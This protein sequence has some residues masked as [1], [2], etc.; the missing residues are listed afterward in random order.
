MDLVAGHRDGS[1]THYNVERGDVWHQVP[2][3]SGPHAGAAVQH[4]AWVEA[5]GSYTGI[6]GLEVRLPFGFALGVTFGCALPGPLTSP[7]VRRLIHCPTPSPLSPA[8]HLRFRHVRF[9][10]RPPMASDPAPKP[11][12]PADLDLTKHTPAVPWPAPPTALHMLVSCDSRG[13]AC[14]SA[15]GQLQVAVV[16]LRVGQPAGGQTTGDVAAQVGPSRP[17]CLRKSLLDSTD[18]INI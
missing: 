10:G 18:A 17:P 12:T 15:Y 14:I 8:Q 5:E 9:F 6:P 11:P 16:D 4:M 2:A 7:P 1:I 3:A 13:M